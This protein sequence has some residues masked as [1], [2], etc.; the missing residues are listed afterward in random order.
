MPLPFLLTVKE[1]QTDV[2][3]QD[4]QISGNK[5]TQNLDQTFGPILWTQYTLHRGVMKMT[6]QVSPM[7]RMN[8]EKVHL[9]LLERG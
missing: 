7:G 3:F 1:F 9:E 6:A 8:R 5:V 2:T 4:W